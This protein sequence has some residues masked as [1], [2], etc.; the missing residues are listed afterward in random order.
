MCVCV[1][2]KKKK[3]QIFKSVKLNGGK[4][5]VFIFKGCF[6][7]MVSFFVSF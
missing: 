4:G 1:V 7:V 2:K 5:E 6:L 3:K